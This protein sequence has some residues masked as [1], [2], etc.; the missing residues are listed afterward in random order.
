MAHPKDGDRPGDV[1]RH[2]YVDVRRK[3]NELH[4]LCFTCE[5]KWRSIPEPGLWARVSNLFAGLAP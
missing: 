1:C 5:L 3:D 2:R 4:W